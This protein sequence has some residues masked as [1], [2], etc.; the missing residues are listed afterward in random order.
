MI[1]INLCKEKHVSKTGSCTGI[2][3]Y[4]T[5]TIVLRL[6]ELKT[7]RS[8]MLTMCLKFYCIFSYVFT[9]SK[10]TREFAISLIATVLILL[11]E[12]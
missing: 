3:I 9:V 12:Y 1:C 4:S 8:V 6:W 7:K 10:D 5:C 11:E 2:K